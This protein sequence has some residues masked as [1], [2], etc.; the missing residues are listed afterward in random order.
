MFRTKTIRIPFIFLLVWL[1]LSMA[2]NFPMLNPQGGRRDK[3]P[4]GTTD[5]PS[6]PALR[7]PEDDTFMTPLPGLNP[8]PTSLTEKIPATIEPPS[9]S[10]DSYVYPAQSG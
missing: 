8:D 4:Q 7:T 6:S 1:L 2:C 5:D 10:A 9:G 3:Q